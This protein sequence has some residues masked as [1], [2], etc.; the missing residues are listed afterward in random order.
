MFR[1][2]LLASAHHLLLFG[3]IAMLALQS[4]LLS[5]PLDAAA[6]RRL[7]GIDRGYGMTA[8][9]LLVFGLARVFHGA[10]GADFY[11]HNPWFH[12]K[13]GLFLLAALLSLWPT[14]TFVRWRRAARTRPD[15]LPDPAQVARMRTIIRLEFALISLILVL[16][17][18]MARH[19]GLGL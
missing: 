14:L 17:A 16:A 1:D 7:V 12:A 15:W 3:L 19:G 18:A 13:L 8:G 5:R 6:L 2:F 9:L 10:K 11:L 4:A